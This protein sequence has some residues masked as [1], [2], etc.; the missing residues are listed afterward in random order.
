[1]FCGSNVMLY[2]VANT[3]SHTF[4]TMHYPNYP[5]EL[6]KFLGN[7]HCQKV[8]GENLDNPFSDRRT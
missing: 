4:I 1:M 2:F 7:L 6:G 3:C 8:V 5:L